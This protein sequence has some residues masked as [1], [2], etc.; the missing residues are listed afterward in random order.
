MKQASSIRIPSAL[1]EK[2]D[3]LIKKGYYESRSEF[4]SASI[5]YGLIFYADLRVLAIEME[6]SPFAIFFKMSLPKPIN[7]KV[8]GFEL[9]MDMKPKQVEK[10][11]DS[12]KPNEASI[13]RYYKSF[14]AVFLKT[15]NSFKGEKIQVVFKV[16]D[17]LREKS[18]VMYRMDYGLSKK[19][20]FVK[21]SIIW[22][23]VKLFETDYL[24]NE[25]D[26]YLTEMKDSYEDIIFSM[27]FDIFSGSSLF[28]TITGTI[29][30]FFDEGDEDNGDEEDIT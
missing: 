3:E 27:F 9:L 22:L 14:T 16:P 11:N 12:E 28:N 6:N 21:A 26:R 17:S 5:R 18:K 30:G 25:T 19:M 23:V 24:Y 13:K 20:D 2:I 10:S 15:F 29:D 8:S 7:E 1:L 4:V